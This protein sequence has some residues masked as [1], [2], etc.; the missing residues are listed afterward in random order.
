[1]HFHFAIVRQF[2]RLAA[3]QQL[4]VDLAGG[5]KGSRS[6]DKRQHP[7]IGGE[8]RVRGRIRK[9]RNLFHC[10]GR[11]RG[12]TVAPPEEEGR[13]RHEDDCHGGGRVEQ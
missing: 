9:G 10:E 1:M 6:V 5:G 2:D 13:H 3:G 11:G 8:R 4:Y 7:A 12:D